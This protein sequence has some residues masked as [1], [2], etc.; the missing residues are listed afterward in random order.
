MEWT[1]VYIMLL[2]L[3]VAVAVHKWGCGQGHANCSNTVKDTDF[4]FNKH[5]S[6]DSQDMTP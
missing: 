3:S 4:K 1:M 6:R 2:L 5:V